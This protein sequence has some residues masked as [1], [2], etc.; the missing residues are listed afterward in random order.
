MRNF[1]FSLLLI[2]GLL[3]PFYSLAQCVPDLQVP[4]RAG[5]YPDTLPDAQG[6]EFYEEVVT[7][8]LPRD[9]TG[10]VG[11]ITLT[12]LF[13]T[14]TIDSVIGL[15][16][17]FEWE[18]NLAPNCEYVVSYDSANVDTIGCIRIFGTT[19]IPSNYNVTVVT[20]ASFAILGQVSTQPFNLSAPLKVNPCIF[21]G[22]CY[23]LS[24][25]G[26]CEPA[27]LSITNNIPS[28]G[29][30]GFSYD[31]SISSP[32]GYNFTSQDENPA[33]QILNAGEYYVDYAVEIDTIGYFMTNARIDAVSCT[34]LLDGADLY[35]YLISP[36]GDTLVNTSANP[37]SN[38]GSNLPVLTGI[39]T[40]VLDTGIYEL[41]VWDQDNIIADAGCATNNQGSGASLTLTTPPSSEDSLT[42][43][44][45]GLTVTFFFDHPIQEITCQD[46]F[47]IFPVPNAPSLEA[48]GTAVTTNEITWC[49]TDELTLAA[50][51]D[52][53]E[54]WIDDAIQVGVG[55]SIS[56]QS[57]GVYE[58]YVVNPTTFCRSEAT[59]VTIVENEVD[60][61]AVVAVADTIF[62]G[63]PST[64]L[65]YNWF[66][67]GGMLVGSGDR[68]TP[69]SSGE[70]FAVAVEISSNCSSVGSDTVNISLTALEEIFAGSLNIYPNPSKG[71]FNLAGIS[72]KSE[73]AKIELVDMVGRKI[74][75]WNRRIPVGNFSLPLEVN[76]AQ[77]GLYLLRIETE[78]GLAIRKL[79]LK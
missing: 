62:I 70:Y 28:N 4:D 74:T 32:N 10:S 79:I 16:D 9:S 46:T 17:G 48:N 51:G 78:N 1:T 64:D 27:N 36:S 43:T 5:I 45:G 54:W 73:M 63:S 3:L 14:F 50:S 26:T 69:D 29:K 53:I 13:Q 60:P 31:W 6:C 15:P 22:D 72:E 35:W 65:T 20:T 8:V 44:S 18:C 67:L 7:F 33:D 41:Q 34:D 19:E 39:T 23:S 76:Q 66:D 38:A 40:S 47:S 59:S 21:E 12:A 37:L 11:G 71:S 77:Q 68:F 2:G 49:T 61:P 58:A 42:V 30:S 57:G 24:L 25:D 56:V 55:K 52:S 75:Q